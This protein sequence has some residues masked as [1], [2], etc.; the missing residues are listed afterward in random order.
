MTLF[1]KTLLALATT[2]AMV[3]L[4]LAQTPAM[5][6]PPVG[7]TMTDT[8]AFKDGKDGGKKDQLAMKDGKD[9]GKK[10]QLAM[11]D[12]KDGGKKGQ[13]AM[14]EVDGK[15]GQLAFKDVDGKKGQLAFKD[16]KDG[17]KK[18]GATGEMAALKASKAI[19]P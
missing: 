14:K 4:A 13:L 12:G 16:G 2:A 3:P 9:G 7:K 11:K 1:K 5:S 10:D 8:A 17:G 18:M 6:K 15:K 19:K